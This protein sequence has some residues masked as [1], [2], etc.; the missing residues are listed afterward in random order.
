MAS[1]LSLIMLAGF[2]ADGDDDSGSAGSPGGTG[3]VESTGE[4]SSTLDATYSCGG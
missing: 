2:P 4:A 1:A 3:T